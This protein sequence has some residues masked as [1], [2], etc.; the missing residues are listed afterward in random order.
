M[1][2]KKFH[3]ILGLLI[4]S[5]TSQAQISATGGTEW[6]DSSLIPPSR[7]A[8]HNEFLNNQYIFP[9]KPRNQWE[10]GLKVGSPTINGDVNAKFPA[11]GFGV[12]VRKSIGYI[13]S[14]RAEFNH[15][16]ASGLN[17]KDSYNYMS[18]PAWRDNGYNGNKRIYTGV[19]SQ[20]V[21]LVTATDRVFYNYKTNLN[22]LS[23]QMLFNL[24]NIRFHKA[25]PKFGLYAILGAGVTFYEA[26]V[27]ALNASGQKYNFNTI[28]GGTWATRNDTKSAL[29]SLL[30]GTYE[31]AGDSNSQYDTKLFGK[32]AR[33]SGTVGFGAAFKLS[34]RVNIAIEDRLTFLKD[35]LLDA[36]RWA[37]TPIGDATP[38]THY[39]TYNF[40]SLGININLF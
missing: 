27:D 1:T 9:A 7:L 33:M 20:N 8:Q 16:T 37:A 36:Q 22:D 35:D 12:H 19:G 28:P 39:D 15:G 32:T 30:D 13:V 24:S 40:I 10:L 5:A 6:K 34:K 25:V 38:T 3:F 26:K 2:I 11:F 23:A 29:K 14:L 21:A 18:N 17:W 4:L 31:T